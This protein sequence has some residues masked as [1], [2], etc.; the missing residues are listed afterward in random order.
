MSAPTKW[1]VTIQIQK[2]VTVEAADE[3]A[4]GDAAVR[5]VAD[6]CWVDDEECE[7]WTCHAVTPPKTPEA[8]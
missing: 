3:D 4:A 5:R 2:T 7:V 1:R 8:A 6:D